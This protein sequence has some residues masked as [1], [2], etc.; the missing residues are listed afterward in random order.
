[1]LYSIYLLLFYLYVSEKLFN[2]AKQ[3]TRNVC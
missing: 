3:N 1:M 2:F